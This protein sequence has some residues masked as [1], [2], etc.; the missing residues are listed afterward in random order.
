MSASVKD[1][2]ESNEEA[3]ETNDTNVNEYKHLKQVLDLDSYHM[4]LVGSEKRDPLSFELIDE[5]EPQDM[6]HHWDPKTFVTNIKIRFP[7]NDIV[8][9][10][11]DSSVEVNDPEQDNNETN[12][13]DHQPKMKKVR[14]D[15]KESTSSEI[16][17]PLS[18]TLI[19]RKEN[20][21]RTIESNTTDCVPKGKSKQNKK[22]I[23]HYFEEEIRWNFANPSMPTPA[24]Y[25][26]NIA[27]DFGLSWETSIELQDSIQK[28]L[29]AYVKANIFMPC[30]TLRDAAGK[31][32]DVSVLVSES[33]LLYLFFDCLLIQYIIV[34]YSMHKRSENGRRHSTSCKI[35]HLPQIVLPRDQERRILLTLL[36]SIQKLIIFI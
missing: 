21:N 7:L 12:V 28:Q 4:G 11:D 8:D 10:L 34:N 22:R 33:F 15:N 16:D 26:M 24:E 31:K 25:V 9:D 35:L 6:N 18:D 23:Q 3:I 5:N 30:V 29:Q 1:T 19:E 13:N 2:S 14:L 27:S 32:R 36:H 17:T 20:E